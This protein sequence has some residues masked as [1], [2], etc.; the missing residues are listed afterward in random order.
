MTTYYTVYKITNLINNKV[1]VGVHKTDNLNDGYMGSGKII[2]SS[3]EKHGIENFKKEIIHIFDNS[4]EA[5]DMESKIVTEEFI[6]RDD[7]YN[8]RIGGIG[9][10]DHII[11][12]KYQLSKE[13]RSR[14]GNKLRGRTFT[15]E[16]KDKMSISRKLYIAS[17]VELPKGMLGKEHSEE[18]KEKIAKTK[19]GKRNPNFGKIWITDGI[20]NKHILKSEVIPDGWNRGMTVSDETK[21]KQS[22]SAKTR[23]IRE[24]NTNTRHNNNAKKG[25]SHVNFGKFWITDGC[26]NIM[27]F[28]TECIPAGWKKGMTVVKQF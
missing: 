22:E 6:S 18:T 5:Y 26:S 8:I 4:E 2:K 17:G 28:K 16:S 15:S 23:A 20:K 11:P 13:T 14:I 1:Y 12:G 19:E 27:I 7:T 10:W 25:K 21:R 9:G 3:V 24:K